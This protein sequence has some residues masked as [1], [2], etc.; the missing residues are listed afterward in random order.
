VSFLAP[1]FLLGTA[2]AAIPIVLHLLKREPEVRVKFAAVRMLRR[3]PVEQ[4]ER[5]RLRELL[6]LALRVAAL[7]LLA[8][9]FA[10]PYFRSAIA[11]ATEGITVV[12]L[13]T[14]LSLSA[15][16]RFERARE[17][18]KEAVARA[19]EGR[20]V[21]VITFA[22]ASSLASEPSLDR[23][24][25]RSAID[26]AA[27]GFGPTRYRAALAHASDLLKGGPGT[28][29]IISDLQQSG[30][31]A[32]DR[33]VV[34]ES[35]RIEVVDVGPPLP[36]LAVTSVGAAGDRVVAVV[37]NVGPASGEAREARV[38]LTV[39]D[40]PAGEGSAVIGPGESAE[41]RLPAAAGAVG[42]VTVE[43][44]EGVQADNTRYLVLDLESRPAILVV[45]A[46]GN[47]ARE[48]FYVQHALAA[49]STAAAPYR[50]VAASGTGLSGWNR[51]QLAT[52]AAVLLLSTRGLERAGRDLLSQYV[53]EGG[54]LLVAAGP[55]VDG[56]VAAGLLAGRVTLADLQSNGAQ[57]AP[58]SGRAFTPVDPRHPLFHAF[59][60]RAAA[61]AL[62]SFERIAIIRSEA[63]QTLARFTSGE[64]A[65]VDCAPGEGRALVL[66]S[67]LD[68]RWNDF[69]RHA[70]FVPFVHEAVRYLSGPRPKAAEYLIGAAPAGLPATPGVVTLPGAGGLSRRVAINV[71]PAETDPA[72]LTAEQ[73]EAA[74]TRVPGGV[75]PQRPIED[76]QRE[77]GQRLWQ[78]LLA[79]MLVAM[80]V[81]SLVAARTA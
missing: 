27:P 7:L 81:E 18:A 45:T 65:L 33:V 44:P 36:N 75:A 37:R 80:L 30:W 40:K 38:R 24:A 46:S 28:I 66:A 22:D 64:A 56:E 26:A 3:G 76:A 35:A 58:R 19:P 43:D 1:L 31:K 16:G 15:P 4:T 41:I 51:A 12:A 79:V 23:N 25:A 29:V 8:L 49:A 77:E 10:R 9:A 61:L 48:A 42:F 47:L 20:L 63:C 62:P 11:I 21:S 53:H 50:I 69:P 34:A 6:L 5:R 14:S 73:L 17:L 57:Q 39:D 2:A 59:G 60:A 70:S 13:D 32:G 52:H 74:V 55:D 71:D 72:R 54:G 67:D 68:N 78:Y